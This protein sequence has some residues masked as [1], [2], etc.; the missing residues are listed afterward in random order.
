MEKIKHILRTT[1]NYSLLKSSK[2]YINFECEKDDITILK[3]KVA[4]INETTVN[5]IKLYFLGTSKN[6]Y[7][8]KL[9]VNLNN[10][11]DEDKIVNLLGAETEK[12]SAG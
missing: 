10:E 5:T 1:Y 11:F 4:M 2:N 3:N 7:I 9:I 12:T 6:L 8:Y